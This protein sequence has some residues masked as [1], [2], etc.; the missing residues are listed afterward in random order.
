MSRRR[1]RS[2]R[3]LTGAAAVA[4]LVAGCA[5]WRGGDAADGADAPAAAAQAKENPGN[6]PGDGATGA[7]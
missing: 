2:F 4:L 7:P 3:P 6:E 5:S 1:I